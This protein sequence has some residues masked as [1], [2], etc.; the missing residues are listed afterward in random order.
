MVF[1]VQ[2]CL[3]DNDI[4][5]V[6]VKSVKSE[7]ELG[8]LIQEY[9]G[10]TTNVVQLVVPNG[11][12]DVAMFCPY[13]RA[14]MEGYSSKEV[15]NY[16]LENMLRRAGINNIS[17][18]CKKA[19]V[20]GCTSDVHLMRITSVPFTFYEEVNLEHSAIN[21]SSPQKECAWKYLMKG[22]C[23]SCVIAKTPC[24]R[25]WPCS[26]CEG[27][28]CCEPSMVENIHVARE[29]FERM[30]LGRVDHSDISKYQIH[31]QTI[32]YGLKPLMRRLEYR[33]IYKRLCPEECSSNIPF[34]TEDRNRWPLPIRGFV[35]DF[36]M[37]KVEWFQNGEY[38]VRSSKAYD[39]EIFNC[40]LIKAL[41]V[42]YKICP[43]LID[44]CNSCNPEDVIVLWNK[45]LANDC[46]ERRIT[47]GCYFRKSKSIENCN[48]HMISWVG[49][50][51]TFVT[52]TG[53]KRVHSYN[54]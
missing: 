6:V 44:Y 35:A 17:A 22:P 24:S 54:L 2:V 46:Q 52:A 41:V 38:L 42:K 34:N 12:Q 1:G 19:I 23:E 39:E 15:V 40:E 50:H 30:R 13:V 4:P 14:I 8:C 21:I 43:K 11:D 32:R 47:M 53:I 9:F 18:R 16:R 49:K 25:V 33:D 51:D 37:W 7:D 26:R 28:R 31:L 29:M 45:S 3:M 5:N 10:D 20:V 36:R 27:K 48:I